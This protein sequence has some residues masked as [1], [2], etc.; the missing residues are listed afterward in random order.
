MSRIVQ[1]FEDP[2][3][4]TSSAT[5]SNVVDLR[6]AFEWTLSF[7]TTAASLSTTTLQLSNAE[8][9]VPRSIAETA[10]STWTVIGTAGLPSGHTTLEPPLGYRFARFI[11]TPPVEHELR[12]HIIER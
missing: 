5:T 10:W 7:R 1:H 9:G 4:G 3:A 12:V 8:G 6:Y 2:F 11:R